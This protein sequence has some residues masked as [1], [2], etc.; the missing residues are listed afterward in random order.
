MALCCHLHERWSR[1]SDIKSKNVIGPIR[2][3]SEE[4][5]ISLA[6]GIYRLHYSVPLRDCL[7]FAWRACKIAQA[8]WRWYPEASD[9]S[10]SC[11]QRR[12]TSGSLECGSPS[13]YPN[14]F[15]ADFSRIPWFARKRYVSG[16]RGEVLP[17]GSEDLL[18]GSR[19]CMI[20]GKKILICRLISCLF[21]QTVFIIA[22]NSPVFNIL[23]IVPKHFQHHGERR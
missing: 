19:A 15:E 22:A 9:D 2:G 13:L 21:V 23:V 6:S 16:G 11:F 1:A 5:S 12:F 14:F 3:L 10:G 17:L 7:H 4:D 18:W 20:L 8:T